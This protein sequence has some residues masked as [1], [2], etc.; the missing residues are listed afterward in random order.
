MTPKDL[1]IFKGKLLSLC[2]TYGVLVRRQGDRRDSPREDAIYFH[3]I[4]LWLKISPKGEEITEVN[5]WK[6]QNFK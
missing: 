4:E 1:E 5:D 6:R 3:E 2:Q